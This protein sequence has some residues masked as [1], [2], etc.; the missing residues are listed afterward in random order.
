[1]AGL[2]GLIWLGL[3]G[4]TKI[5]DVIQDSVEM[6]ESKFII[7]ETGKS[8]YIDREGGYHGTNGELMKTRIYEDQ[9][10]RM[11]TQ[12]VGRRTGTVYKDSGLREEMRNQECKQN[13]IKMGWGAYSRHHPKFRH[14]VACDL[15]TDR[16][17]AAIERN[18]DL[19][20]TTS[21]TNKVYIC[22]KYFL[23]S[24]PVFDNSYDGNDFEIITN[25]EFES[26]RRS[27]CPT[28]LELDYKDL[29]ELKNGYWHYKGIKMIRMEKDIEY[30]REDGEV[31][32]LKK[33]EYYFEYFLE[34]HN[35][36]Y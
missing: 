12:L 25:E 14:C 5:S 8:V 28:F 15:K 30:N 27:T 13:A 35:I 23:Q 17:I 7:P 16:Y 33:G 11:Q 4:A 24:N 31:G 32:I 20:K 29:F 10:G 36:P 34:E 1:M 6:S 18:I 26:I 9:Y 19:D 2:F 21:N 3:F 22:K